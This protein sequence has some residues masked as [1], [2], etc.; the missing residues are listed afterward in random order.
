MLTACNLRF[1]YDETHVVDG[2]SLSL[3]PGEILGLGGTSGSGKST[4]GRLLA[5]RLRPKAGSVCLDDAPLRPVASGRPAPVQY[6]PQNAELA[7]DP[8]W[9]VKRILANGGTPDEEA[10][11]ALGISSAW[12][13]RH[14]CELSGGELARVSLARL[15]HPG[16]RVLICD[17]VTAQLDAL[18]QKGLLDRLSALARKR[19]IGLLLISHSRGL[20]DQYCDHAATLEDG[21]LAAEA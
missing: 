19:A 17:E 5:G 18:E 14:P 11:T 6:A 1:G 13:N 15:F 3:T 7:V 21:R 4:L 10:V 12:L 2:I 20:R 8:R 16:L 9:K